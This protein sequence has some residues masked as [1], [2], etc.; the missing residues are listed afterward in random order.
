MT[1]LA[2]EEERKFNI[3]NT[4]NKRKNICVITMDKNWREKLRLSQEEAAGLAWPQP[5]VSWKKVR[6]S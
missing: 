1:M 2:S 6:T 4:K 3:K 5:S